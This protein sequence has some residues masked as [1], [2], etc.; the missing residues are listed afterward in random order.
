MNKFNFVHAIILQKH[1]WF[2]QN[3]I[4]S[5]TNFKN[6]GTTS[7]LRSLEKTMNNFEI[8]SNK[9]IQIASNSRNTSRMRFFLTKWGRRTKVSGT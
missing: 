7:E 5:A 1:F 9:Q 2:K 6:F 4:K 3:R 8:I